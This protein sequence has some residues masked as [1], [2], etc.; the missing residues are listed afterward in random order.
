[1][2]NN[3]LCVICFKP[4]D[5]WIYFLSTF[6]KYDIYIV[7]DD[8]EID[9]KEKY[10]EFKKINIIQIL[11][12]ECEK[13]GYKNINFV[14][15]K[16]ISG[17]D[18]AIYYFSKIN[19]LYNYI[20]FLEDDVFFYNEKTI[21]NIDLKYDNVDLLSNKYTENTFG[22]K[23]NWHWKDLKI[24]INPPY[25]NAMVCCTRMSKN[26]MLKIKNYA[27][28]Y[29]TLFFLE[30]LFPTLCKKYNLKYETPSELLNII[31]RKDYDKNDIDKINI[32][33]PLKDINMHNYY[34]NFL[35]HKI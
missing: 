23:D 22:H 35:E 29:K 18:K 33:H 20:W 8:N 7:V 13:D 26:L 9:Y 2:K 4:N 5:I 3:Y 28:E 31:Y 34:R 24:H 25:Y 30:A 12:E 1:M 6:E 17:W 21:N 14:I 15:K 27:N 32:Y 16:N 11:N 19:L 10:K